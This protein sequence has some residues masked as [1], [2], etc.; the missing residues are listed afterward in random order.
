MTTKKT[1]LFSFLLCIIIILSIILGLAP[2]SGFNT[3]TI[4]IPIQ[5]QVMAYQ[6][7]QQQQGQQMTLYTD[8]IGRFTVDYPSRWQ[9]IVPP[10]GYEAF[11]IV[12]INP[13]SS[14]E[15]VAIISFPYS[16]EYD[17]ADGL[18][19]E[20]AKISLLQEATERNTTIVQDIE[21]QKYQIKGHIA[22]S[23]I[24]DIGKSKMI[25]V[26]T[27]VGSWK[28]GIAYASL[29]EGFNANLPIFEQML[30]SFSVTEPEEVLTYTDVL[31]KFT[32]D[33]P[34]D[35]IKIQPGISS[36]VVFISSQYY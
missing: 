2:L 8:I 36:E 16:P 6:Q 30:Q 17:D 23:F 35:W 11:G 32:M 5:H 15:N 22:C 28:Y 1:N 3:T 14:G 27:A 19:E 34:S 7:Q 10:E 18:E 21:C 24:L 4:G 25:M 29:K 33:Y 26:V 13:D 9:V 20:E 12:F 31:Q